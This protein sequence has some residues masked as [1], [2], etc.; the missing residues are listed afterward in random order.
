MKLSRLGLGTCAVPTDYSKFEEI[1]KLAIDNGVT[2]I[3]TGWGYLGPTVAE[4]LVGKFFR[5]NPTYRDKVT[6]IGKFPL[7]R[8]IFDRFTSNDLIFETQCMHMNTDYIDIYMLHALGDAK[9]E[10]NLVPYIKFINKLKDE[11]RIGKIGFSSHCTFKKLRSY[12]RLADWDTVMLSYSY[13]NT[14]PEEFPDIKDKIWDSPGAD[15]IQYC[16]DQGLEVIG[17]TPNEHNLVP[18]NYTKY[19]EYALANENLDCVLTSTSNKDHL[20]SNISIRGD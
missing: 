4:S 5:L 20:L 12:L 2:T 17:M 1:V 16:K 3:D 8:E 9:D 7:W 10:P 11:G 13:V 14:H 15:G 6:L 18:D 19:L